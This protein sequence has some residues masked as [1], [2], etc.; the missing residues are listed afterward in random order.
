MISQG[1]YDAA[2][3]MIAEIGGGESTDDYAERAPYLLAAFC[4]EC[5]SADVDY[6][7]AHELAAQGAFSGVFLELS[8]KFP[9]CERFIYPAECYLASMLLVDED[10]ALSDK[11]YERYCD[12]IS[13]IANELPGVSGGIV[14]RYPM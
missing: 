3:R 12:S 10:E 4:C 9:L 8:E 1:I 7:A 2:L 14:D 6:R 5:A 13:A 11:L